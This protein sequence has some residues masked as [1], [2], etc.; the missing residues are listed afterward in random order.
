MSKVYLIKNNFKENFKKIY[1][2][3]SKNFTKDKTAIKVHFGEEGCTTHLSPELVKTLIKNI[4]NPYLIECN[5]LYKGKRTYA[6][7]HIELAKQH[8]FNFAP[9]IISDGEKGND[10]IEIEINKKHFKTIKIGKELQNFKNLVVFSHFTV[11]F[12]TG[13][14]GALKN[15]G[16][17]LGSRAGKLAMHCKTSITINQEKCIA[18]SVCIENCPVNAIFYINKKAFIDKEKCINCAKCIAVC[19]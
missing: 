4:N 6:K 12:P 7:D 2:D 14:G 15:L 19:P 17:G 8:G 10:Y 16:M 11:H 9:I 5:V 13:F 18:C 1:S 3:L